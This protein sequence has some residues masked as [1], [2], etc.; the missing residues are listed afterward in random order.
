MS[1]PHTGPLSDRGNTSIS[2]SQNEMTLVMLEQ[3]LGQLRQQTAVAEL[4]PLVIDFLRQQP[5]LDLVWVATYLKAEQQL[6]GQ[7]G[8]TA[9]GTPNFL[10]QRF[11]LPPGSLLDQVI[12]QKQ[13]LMVP[14]LRAEVRAGEWCRIAQKLRIQGSLVLPLVVEG[15]C[16]G[17]VLLGSNLWGEIQRGAERAILSILLSSLAQEVQRLSATRPAS[18]PRVLTARTTA[19][20]SEPDA[21]LDPN[22]SGLDTSPNLSQATV[23]SLLSD[24]C[25]YATLTERIDALLRGVQQA[26]QPEQTSLFIWQAEAEQFLRRRTTTDK[27]SAR[28]N[29][30]KGVFVSAQSIPGFCQALRSGQLVAISDAQSLV[31]SQTPVSLLQLLKARAI[32]A[33]PI[34]LGDQLWGFLVANVPDS[35]IWSDADRQLIKAAAK[36]L[37]LFAPVEIAETH[38][39][40]AEQARQLA[41][42]LTQAICSGQDWQA[43]LKNAVEQL[44]AEMDAQAILV[45]RHDRDSQHFQ[46][47]HQYPVPRGKAGLAWLPPLSD[48]DWRHLS[49]SLEPQTYTDI[50]Q[51]LRLIAWQKQLL[52]L[53]CPAWLIVPTQFSGIPEN[54]IA[55]GRNSGQPWLTAD[56]NLATIIARQL[57]VLTH[58][59]Q[60]QQA[61]DRQQHLYQA[62][63]SGL[64][65]MQKTQNLER[66][67]LAAIQSLMELLQSP[68]ALLVTWNPGQTQAWI[69]APPPA[70]PKFTVRVNAQVDVAQDP[71]IQAALD[72]SQADPSTFVNHP[73]PFPEIVQLTG[74][75]ISPLTREWLDGA[76]IGKVLALALRTDPEYQPSGVV[77][78]ADRLERTWPPAYLEAFITLVNHLAYAHRSIALTTH[79]IQGWQ[80]LETLNWY[81]HRRLESL[82]RQLGQ[83]YQQLHQG[84]TSNPPAATAQLARVGQQFQAQLTTVVPLIQQEAWQLL[85]PHREAE[86][87]GLSSLLKRSL[88]RIEGLVKQKQL[89]TQVH[90]PG[91]ISLTGDINKFDLI[92]QEL[93]LAAAQRTPEGGRIDVWCQAI[94]MQWL[95]L[96]I[97]DDGAIDPRL[98]IDLHHRDHLDWLAPSTLDH[99]P[100]RHL[101]ACFAMVKQLGATLDI[102]KLEDGR[103]LSRIILPI[104]PPQPSS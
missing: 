36:F 101:R 100:G 75:D 16:L 79:L 99:P 6:Q 72:N 7:G 61:S 102:Y 58:Q 90:N 103:V 37:A 38:L 25:Q 85:P 20:Q 8:H 4:W 65:T 12:I 98:L 50:E 13:P 28:E 32:L 78:V 10:K 45:L 89:W 62:L 40:Q 59:W 67:E 18:T 57:G 70:Q 21:D 14:D 31:G 82:Y 51:D 48:L 73:N 56:L 68:L 11:P 52:S 69:V 49:S 2:R 3:T 94:D 64:A 42:G 83:A 55:I 97:T 24:V 53:K 9:A 74:A 60:L 84:L 1:N 91:M 43:V 46:V 95:E 81:K 86:S 27:L 96:S 63:R 80:Q 22:P 19:P 41:S 71:L 35:R 54:F 39:N 34:N 87:I 5:G 33:A 77:I 26:L 23:A 47:I 93:L 104:N 15:D 92:L 76:E 29:E 66:L 44:A 17:L 30:R 88:D